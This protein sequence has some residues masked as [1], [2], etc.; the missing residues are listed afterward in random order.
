MSLTRLPTWLNCELLVRRRLVCA[1]CFGSCIRA[2]ACWLWGTI[3]GQYRV[4]SRLQARDGAV[5]PVLPT[6]RAFTALLR[7]ATLFLVCGA[8]L[9]F[10]VHS[11]SAC[12]CS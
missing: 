12:V 5:P 6:H 9:A 8:L 11:F 3:L 7:V 1:F 4:E 10:T 2:R